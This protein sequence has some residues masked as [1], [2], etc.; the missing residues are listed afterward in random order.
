MH[1]TNAVNQRR[2]IRKFIRKR[3]VGQDLLLKLVDC[4]RLAPSAMNRQVLRYYLVTEDKADALMPFTG[5]AGYLPPER[6]RPKPEEQPPAFI[7]VLALKEQINPYY[8]LDI[9]AA[10]ENI[11]L[12]ALEY[13]LATCWIGSLM[14]E[15][16]RALLGIPDEYELSLCI[17]VGYPAQHSRAVKY[18]GDIRYTIDEDDSLNVPKLSLDEV[19][20]K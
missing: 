10:A 13:G 16:A 6:G 9:G 17:A 19:L 5:W 4:A 20:V 7:L 1:V 2:S 15:E 11:S 3:A 8:K 12:A 18:E 14:A